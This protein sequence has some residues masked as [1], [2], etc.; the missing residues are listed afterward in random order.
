MKHS[1]DFGKKHIELCF[2]GCLDLFKT[3][4]MFTRLPITTKTLSHNLII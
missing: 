1:A 2:K 3:A 4:K